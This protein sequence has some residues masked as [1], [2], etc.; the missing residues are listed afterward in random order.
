MPEALETSA[1]RGSLPAG[2]AAELHAMLGA[3]EDAVRW[4]RASLDDG[5]WVDQYLRVNSAYDG[6]RHRDDFRAI[7]EQVGA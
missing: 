4:L 6:M 7:L 1:Q 2:R 5:T 3:D